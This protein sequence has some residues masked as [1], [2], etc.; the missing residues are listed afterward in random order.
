MRLSVVVATYQQP[1]WLRKVIWG[2]GAQTEPPAEVLI[3][4]D[5]SGPETRAVVAWAGERLGVPVRHV[6]QE[7]AGFRKCAIVNQ[8]I[9]EAR[10]DYLVFLDGDC[11][12]RA[13]FLAT[14][15]RLARPGRFLSGGAFR[16]TP[17]VSAALAEADVVSQRAFRPEWLRAQ[18]M[19]G[20]RRLWR[21]RA[22]GT[23]AS[24]LDRVTTTR[25]T[26][27][28]GNSSAWRHDLVTVNGFDERMGHSWED[29]ELGLRLSHIGVTGLQVRHRAVVLHLEHERAYRVRDVV[30]QNRELYLATRRTHATR[31]PQGLDRHRMVP[32]GGD[33][34]ST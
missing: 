8:A 26:F 4:D 9:L 12:P 21:M 6:W 15:H 32:T 25:A 1:E 33:Q 17:L 30:A 7:D 27:N 11:V 28:G 19:P 10:G 3:A 31:T 13:D 2:L 5:G 29:R 34:S 23:L 18:G 24:L 20:G 16:L 22:G 14:H